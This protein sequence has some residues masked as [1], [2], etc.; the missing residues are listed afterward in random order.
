[1]AGV[2]GRRYNCGMGI[3]LVSVNIEGQKH[4]GS[5]G[6]FLAREDTEIVC[7]MEACE[8]DVAELC[9]GKYPYYEYAPNDVLTSGLPT[10]V[11]IISKQP[12]KR[13]EQYYCGEDD[14]AY[15]VN[16][17]MGTHA[18]VLLIAEVGT[19]RIGAV[20]FS[21]T[22]NGSIDARQ[23]KDTGVLL[24]YLRTKGELVVCGD[25]N[26]PRPNK[27]YR[28]LAL[29]YR[30]NIPMSITTTIDPT[31]HYANKDQP[32]KLETVVDYVWSTP[33]Y[34]VENVR[35]ECGVSDHCAVVCEINK[36][37]S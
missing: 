16:P 33:Q 12:M 34:R 17:G 32:G 26:I 25:F 8:T 30:D 6:E 4:L 11:V 35:V 13:V 22:P 23:K 14:R 7:L 3:K 20:H 18:P 29:N 37:T 1:L 27:M 21:W 2:K 31:L 9:N 5:V 19:M 24:D 28:Q 36:V 15:L 10:G